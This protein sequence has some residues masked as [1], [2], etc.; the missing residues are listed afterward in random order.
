MRYYLQRWKFYFSC[1]LFSKRVL[2][3]HIAVYR[4]R[5]F[6]QVDKPFGHNC[7]AVMLALWRCV[8]R[9]LRCWNRIVSTKD[10]TDFF[11][12]SLSLSRSP[13]IPPPFSSS[14]VFFL[15]QKGKSSSSLPLESEFV[16]GLNSQAYSSEFIPV[17]RISKKK[18]KKDPVICLVF[19]G[20]GKRCR[21][22]HFN[23]QH[24]FWVHF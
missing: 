21:A 24:L 1:N 12:F 22:L 4:K 8:Y 5:M 7:R 6:I 16:F 13:S 17:L 10:V 14:Q 19:G 3:S 11:S 9:A 18:K 20:T 2:A 15:R 23:R